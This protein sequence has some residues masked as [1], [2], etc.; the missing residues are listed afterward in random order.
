MKTVNFKAS[1]RWGQV[2]T[3]AELL[4]YANHFTLQADGRL[5]Y[6]LNGELA[7]THRTPGGYR[8]VS[9]PRA[10]FWRPNRGAPKCQAHR[11]VFAMANPGVDIPRTC[12]IDHINRD[13]T[14][15]RPENLRLVDGVRQSLNRVTNRPI[16]YLRESAT[17]A[18]SLAMNSPHGQI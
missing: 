5:T 18:L 14:D 2:M 9:N 11:L 4:Q 6:Q 3:T 10:M 15:N 7:D 1:D 8:M 13:R 17:G 12:Q 16:P